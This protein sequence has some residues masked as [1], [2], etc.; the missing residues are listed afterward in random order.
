MLNKEVVHISYCI[1]LH[2][3]SMLFPVVPI[4]IISRELMSSG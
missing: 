1:N 2:Y 4:I 3:K